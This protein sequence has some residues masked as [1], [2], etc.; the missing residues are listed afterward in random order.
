M[1]I[2]A[3]Q[4]TFA[5][6]LAGEEIH[7]PP[8]EPHDDW[9]PIH[10]DPSFAKWHPPVGESHIKYHIY[11]IRRT[12]KPTIWRANS[13]G[14]YQGMGSLSSRGNNLT[15]PQYSNEFE[16]ERITS[17]S[18]NPNFSNMDKAKAAAEKYHAENYG[19]PQKGIGDYDLNQ[20]MRDQGF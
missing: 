2:Q 17:V 11:P 12:G 15:F 3:Q 14:L 9:R 20:L 19:K 13:H 7:I 4:E 16:P 18:G 5:Y 1:K 6:R 10:G 8:D